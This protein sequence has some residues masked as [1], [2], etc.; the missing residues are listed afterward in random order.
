MAFGVFKLV[1]SPYTVRHTEKLKKVQKELQNW[2]L[3][4][5]VLHTQKDLESWAFLHSNIGVTE[6]T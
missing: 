5:K 2:Y 6:E 1:W 4:A 3:H